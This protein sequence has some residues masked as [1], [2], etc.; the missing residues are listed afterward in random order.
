MKKFIND[1]KTLVK[2][3]LDGFAIARHGETRQ[4]R[5]RYSAQASEQGSAGHAARTPGKRH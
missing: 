4:D 1:P 5:L 2:E 3:L